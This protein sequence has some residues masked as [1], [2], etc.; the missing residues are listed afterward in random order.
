MTSPLDLMGIAE[1]IARAAGRALL[2]LRGG[3]FDVSMKSS[4]SDPVS[5]ADLAS[6]ELILGELSRLRPSDG[7][8]SEEGANRN[9]TSGLTWVIDPLDGTVNYLRGR[10]EFGV[11]IAVVDEDGPVA[12]CVHA[13]AAER[14]FTAARGRGAWRDGALLKRGQAGPLETALVGTGFSY[15]ANQR[16]VQGQWL[17][18][19][20][21]R[22]AD[23][24]R[25]GAA[26][27]DICAVADG[28]LDAFVESDLSEWDIVA[29]VLVA[30]ES[31]ALVEVV[32]D[33]D[34]RCVLVTAPG[35]SIPSPCDA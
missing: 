19:L 31:G 12:G 20:L 28:S 24:R 4:D 14:C 23:I 17:A 8:L 5:A 13:P 6:Q 16:G 34:R 3:Q 32:S 33:R 35:I 1:L 11:S 22:I 26:A 2:E 18:E 25:L 15:D 9:G 30:R 21:P 27:L 10:D 29:G 7:V